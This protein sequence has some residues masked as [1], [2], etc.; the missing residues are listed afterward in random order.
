MD[1]GHNHIARLSE[2]LRMRYHAPVGKGLL[3]SSGRII[4]IGRLLL[5][6]LFLLAILLDESQP[7]RAPVATY[8]LL[9]VYLLFASAIVIATWHSWWLDAKLAG[10]AHAVDIMLFT[11]LVLL[12]EGYTSPFF[13]FFMFSLLSAAIRWGW[14]ATALTAVLLTMLYL[15]VGQ[16]VVSFGAP[17]EVPRFLVRTGHLIILSLILIWFGALRWRA[18]ARLQDDEVLARSSLDESPLETGLRTA[19]K[20]IGARKGVFIWRHKERDEF[21]G[22]AIRDGEVALVTA[23]ELAMAPEFATAPFLYDIKKNRGLRKDERRDLIAFEVRDAISPRAASGLALGK[24]LAVPVRVD[25]G[26][27]ELFLEGPSLST[28]HIDI[29]G[30]ITADVAAH[31]QSHALLKAAEES[32]EARS[33]LMLARDLH[34]S[35]VQFLAGAAFRLEAM[36]RFKASGRE[37]EP[38]LDELK[39]LMLQE[40]RELRSFISALRSGPLVA[41][42]D[43]A[44]DL[45][46]LADRLSRHWDVR[47]EFSARPAELMIPTRLRLDA[48]HLMREAVANAVRH[49]QAKSIEV[50]LEAVSEELRL[51]FINDGAG[52]R[53][54]GERL[55]LPSSLRERVEQAGGALDM[56]RGM[57]VTKLSIS[58]PIGGRRS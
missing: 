23:P 41:L 49:A 50:G 27:G 34:D 10:P 35:V 30:Q 43:L 14:R 28:D 51:E 13:T 54:R 39:Q 9:G 18:P 57:G 1:L 21:G 25:G 31:L 58:L 45:R 16:L 24:G 6:T 11:L 47:C 5:A 56:A 46:A 2:P 20:I 26:E 17:F 42:N 40:Q 4:A 22:Y 3:H 53:P 29:G 33:R 52:F 19:M 55:E 44:A 38:E 36:K 48:Q 32:A 37:I 8:S 7:A 15:I 12:T